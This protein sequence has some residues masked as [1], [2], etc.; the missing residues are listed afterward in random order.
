M[1]RR[2]RADATRNREHLLVAAT[3]LFASAETEP[4]MRAIA[5][6]AG[7]GIATLYRH[8]PTRESLVDAVYRGQVSR[9]T[10]S[11]GELLTH[12]DPPAAL[13]RWMDL[14]GDWIATKNGMLDT[15][16][17]MIESGE[18]AHAHT[19]TE[20]LAAIDHILEAGRT[21]GELRAD[22]SAEDIAAALIGIFTVAGSPER[23]AMAARLLNLLMDGLQ[24]DH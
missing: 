4:S 13:R 12:L 15:L 9:L 23:A 10:A 11:A 8:F 5:N 6:E 19:R 21:S 14:F 20:L 24:T 22:V 7:V 17:A 16:L 2:P 1:T 3:R 18:I